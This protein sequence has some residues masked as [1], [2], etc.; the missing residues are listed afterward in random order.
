MDPRKATTAAIATLSAAR[1]RGVL[2]RLFHPVVRRCRKVSS[3][4]GH[5]M[6]LRAGALTPPVSFVLPRR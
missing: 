5:S 2:P 6:A 3:A 1:S 4:L